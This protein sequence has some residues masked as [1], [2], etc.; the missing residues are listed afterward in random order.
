MV[1]SALTSTTYCIHIVV[2]GLFVKCQ[3]MMTAGSTVFIHES[4][5]EWYF[6]VVNSL[7]GL[8]VLFATKVLASTIT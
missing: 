3:N 8:Q 5:A 1:L 6:G 2:G 4:D 7:P